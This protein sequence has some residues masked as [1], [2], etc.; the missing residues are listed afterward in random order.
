MEGPIDA[1]KHRIEGNFRSMAIIPEKQ[2]LMSSLFLELQRFKVLSKDG[3]EKV[4]K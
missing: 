1:V 2:L 3:L 4:S